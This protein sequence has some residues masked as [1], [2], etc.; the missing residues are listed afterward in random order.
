MVYVVDRIKEQKAVLI[1]DKGNVSY[2]AL[3]KLPAG[4]DEGA[5]LRVKVDKVGRHYWKSA[6]LD[7]EERARRIKHAEEVLRQLQMRDP[8][9]DIVL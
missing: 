7:E 8:G 3:S 6:R 9:G 4:V 2:A 1:N 5:V